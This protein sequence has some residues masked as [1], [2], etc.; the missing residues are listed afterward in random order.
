MRVVHTRIDDRQAAETGSLAG[1]EAFNLM[2]E[3]QKS[4]TAMPA[5]LVPHVRAALD[6][7]DFVRL[8]LSKYRGKE[9]ELQRADVRLIEVGNRPHLS[10][11][12]H[13]ETRDV[14]TNLLV[15]DGLV[16]LDE[17]L[18]R[19]FK[20]GNLFTRDEEVE[21]QYSRKG[22]LRITR[23]R[24]TISREAGKAEHNRTKERLL[25]SS[26]RFLR[27]L[28]VA[29]ASGRVLPSMSDKWKQINRFLEIL[30]GALSKVTLQPGK[31]MHVVDFGAGKGY[32]TFAVHHYLSRTAETEARV[33]G[34]ELRPHLVAFCCDVA[35]RLQL[36]GLKFVEGDIHSFP[37]LETDILIALHA[38][39]T[40]TDIALYSGIRAG[41]RVLLAS[42]CCHK[43]L[44][45][46]MVIPEVLSPLLR[47]GL[48]LERE[49]E[50]VTDTL[51]ALLLEEAGYR[52]QIMEFI[53]SEHTDKNKLLVATRRTGRFDPAIYRKRIDALKDFY[54]I[55]EHHLET[56]LGVTGGA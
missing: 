27:E 6:G 4:T 17:L 2:D 56:L 25:D 22:R 51:R 46:Q 5:S 53:S 33:T 9:P 34:V 50:M 28:G 52:V 39:D 1:Q 44:R 23:R 31:P 15:R 54:G 8:V 30:V 20:A 40:A 19:E 13:Y 42:P 24:A 3:K 18:G 11:V 37:D 49:A 35:T 55:T 47:Y 16:R 45:P 7:G 26:V 43:Q 41:A 36:D 29:G 38:C 14:T 48:H 32:L 10:F 21:A 12:F